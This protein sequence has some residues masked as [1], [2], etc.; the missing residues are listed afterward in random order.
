[1]LFVIAISISAHSQ[2]FTAEHHGST[3]LHAAAFAGLTGICEV[4]W[5]TLHLC[6]VSISSTWYTACIKHVRIHAITAGVVEIQSRRHT[7]E[8]IWFAAPRRASSICV[9]PRV[10][11]V[12]R[13]V[14]CARELIYI[15]ILHSPFV[16]KYLIFTVALACKNKLP[17]MFA[18]AE[19]FYRRRRRNSQQCLLL[20]R[21]INLYTDIV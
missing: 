5:E 12:P 19:S 20:Q 7:P 21:T 16:E 15:M 11:F 10:A 1:M 9:S 8:Q 2:R 18:A 6:H 17:I 13:G 3:A 4:M 14:V